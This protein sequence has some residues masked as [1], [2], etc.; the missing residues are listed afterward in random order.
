MRCPDRFLFL[1]HVREGFPPWAYAVAQHTAGDT[2]QT[3]L[4]AVPRSQNA[5]RLG[6]KHTVPRGAALGT[7][8]DEEGLWEVG[9]AVAP[10]WVTPG[11]RGR[12]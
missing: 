8:V 11:P 12:M 3:R 1:L 7:G 4:R 9:S 10:G 2:G 5:R 6:E